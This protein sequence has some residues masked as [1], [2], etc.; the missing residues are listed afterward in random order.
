MEAQEKIGAEVANKLV[1]FSDNGSSLSSVNF[2]EVTLPTH[3]GSHRLL[4]IHKNTPGI[5]SQINNFFSE[6]DINIRAQHLQTNQDVGYVVTDIDQEYSQMALSQLNQIS[7]T[8]KTR[9]LF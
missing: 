7:G 9:V 1:V 3:T 6:N 5:L 8:I 4:H 2:P